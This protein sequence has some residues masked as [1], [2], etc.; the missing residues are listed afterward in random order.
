M[1][2]S[3]GIRNIDP[4]EKLRCKPTTVDR[5]R[6]NLQPPGVGHLSSDEYCGTD[7]DEWTLSAAALDDSLEKKQLGAGFRRLSS[8][9]RH[10]EVLKEARHYQCELFTANGLALLHRREVKVREVHL[11]RLWVAHGDTGNFL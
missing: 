1:L 7:A 9:A 10:R 8:Y 11:S 3:V 2:L 6:C 5:K 4:N